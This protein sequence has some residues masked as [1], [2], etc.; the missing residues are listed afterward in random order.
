MTRIK[1]HFFLCTVLILTYGPVQSTWISSL[2]RHTVIKM[3]NEQ[4]AQFLLVWV[5]FTWQGHASDAWGRGPWSTALHSRGNSGLFN[6]TALSSPT[7]LCSTCWYIQGGTPLVFTIPPAVFRAN[8]LWIQTHRHSAGRGVGLLSPSHHKPKVTK[9]HKDNWLSLST[10]C[11]GCLSSY[12][13]HLPLSATHWWRFCQP[14]RSK[15]YSDEA[16]TWMS[17]GITPGCNVTGVISWQGRLLCMQDLHTTTFPH[18]TG[19]KLPEGNFCQEFLVRV[20]SKPAGKA[21]GGCSCSQPLLG[22]G[23]TL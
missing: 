1:K 8:M 7:R 10:L 2:L 4:Q 20:T 9:P 18:F 5:M 13:Q 12:P 22:G 17:C 11:F 16:R 21:A 6:R 23:K 15:G 14:T 19:E 3:I